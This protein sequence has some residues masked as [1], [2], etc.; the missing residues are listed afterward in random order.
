MSQAQ[1]KKPEKVGVL[2]MLGFAVTGAVLGGFLAAAFSRVEAAAGLGLGLGVVFALLRRER[3]RSTSLFRSHAEMLTRVD[4]LERTIEDASRVPPAQREQQHTGGVPSTSPPVV[5]PSPFADATPA[6]FAEVTP[7]AHVPSLPPIAP[8][9][10]RR[11]PSPPTPNAFARGINAVRA[12]LF[13]GNTVVRAGVLVLLV[14]I[15]LLARWAAEHSLFPIEARLASAALIGSRAC[16]SD[17][18]CTV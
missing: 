7:R 13:G 6:D 10:P 14:G 8:P 17:S 16:S 1:S 11:P 4:R 3:A 18:L 9:F 2:G 5:A 12:W 15:T